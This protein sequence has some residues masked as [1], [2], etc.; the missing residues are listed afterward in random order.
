MVKLHWFKILFPLNNNFYLKTFQIS[1]INLSKLLDGFNC[2]IFANF[3]CLDSSLAFRSI[4][5]RYPVR[6]V[7]SLQ[8]KIKISLKK[9]ASIENK[10]KI[11]LISTVIGQI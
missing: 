7:S 8:T 1:F 3:I 5:G 2:C 6:S 11:K 4:L 10:E 9:V